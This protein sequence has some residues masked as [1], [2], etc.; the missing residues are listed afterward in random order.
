VEGVDSRINLGAQEL[1]DFRGEVSI[2][3]LMGAAFNVTILVLAL[4]VAFIMVCPL[5]WAPPSI[6]NTT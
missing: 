3:E 4:G 2:E 6:G 5:G 1:G